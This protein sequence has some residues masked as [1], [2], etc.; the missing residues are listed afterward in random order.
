[1]PWI[2]PRSTADADIVCRRVTSH[3]LQAR[4]GCR[5]EHAGRVIGVRSRTCASDTYLLR[6]ADHILEV[7]VSM[8]S[9]RTMQTFGS[10]YELPEPAELPE[11]EVHAF[12]TS[13]LVHHLGLMEKA[14]DTCRPS[15]RR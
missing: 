15:L 12:P 5:G 3:R 2:S 10:S 8:A 4:P 14:S 6:T 11:V 9:V 13:Q 1:M 7:V